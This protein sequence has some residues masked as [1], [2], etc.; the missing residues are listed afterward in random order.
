MTAF[1]EDGND[2]ILA[3][4]VSADGR[5]IDDRLAIWLLNGAREKEYT[6]LLLERASGM[7]KEPASLLGPDEADPESRMIS[8]PRVGVGKSS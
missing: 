8:S 6:E 3:A 2:L 5:F 1:L 4:R 7:T